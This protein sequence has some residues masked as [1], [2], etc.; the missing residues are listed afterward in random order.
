MSPAT[1]A[2]GLAIVPVAPEVARAGP[3]FSSAVST[4]F[5][6]AFALPGPRR[7]IDQADVP[8]CVSSAFAAAAESANPDWEM[9]A[10]LFH[11]FVARTQLMGVS[12]TQTADITLETANEA[13][14]RFGICLDRLHN[15]PMNGQG[16]A[17]EPSS[18]ARADALGRRLPPISV[19][20]P[21]SRIE[22]LS[23][24]NRAIDWKRALLTGKP[25]IA[26]IDLPSDYSKSMRRASADGGRLGPSHAVAILGYR[27]SEQAFIVQD[28][29]GPEWFIGGQ[30]WMPYAFAESGF[31]YRAYSLHFR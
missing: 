25:I 30:W 4:G 15:Q 27:D 3:V 23:D 14:A 10:P 5:P 19:F 18:A 6:P 20:P 26:G 8:C 24:R 17:E 21:V 28:S 9:L 11:Y 29:R 31:V 12:P 7:I 16:V 13:M 2:T 1:L 22:L